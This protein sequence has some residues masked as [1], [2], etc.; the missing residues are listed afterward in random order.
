MN[1]LSIDALTASVALPDLAA[2]G[3]DLVTLAQALDEDWRR[4][5]VDPACGTRHLI[6]TMGHRPDCPPT[7]LSYMHTQLLMPGRVPAEDRPIAE[8]F[9][10]GRPLMTGELIE[11]DDGYMRSADE[12]EMRGVLGQI[13]TDGLV[14]ETTAPGMVEIAF[15]PLC[16]RRPTWAKT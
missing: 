15:T 2:R 10:S 11:E 14:V 7:G 8:R 9:L 13:R 3:N 12:K 1:A 4:F 16:A 5:S 6:S